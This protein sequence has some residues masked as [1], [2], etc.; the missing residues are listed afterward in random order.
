MVFQNNMSLMVNDPYPIYLFF[1]RTHQDEL[2]CRFTVL[3]ECSGGNAF[4]PPPTNFWCKA[5]HIDCDS[6][7]G[8][9]KIGDTG[10]TP[11]FGSSGAPKMKTV[12]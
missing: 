10:E 3:D 9:M 1:E 4:E 8:K 5:A 12:I 2:P 11:E 6:I 7:L